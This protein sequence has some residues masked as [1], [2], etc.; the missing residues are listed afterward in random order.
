MAGLKE[1]GLVSVLWRVAQVDLEVGK[2]LNQDI[3]IALQK[4]LILSM[5]RPPSL[6]AMYLVVLLVIEGYYG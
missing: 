1:N 6:L 3:L 5:P 4:A 2:R